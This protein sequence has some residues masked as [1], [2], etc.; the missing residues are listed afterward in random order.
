MGDTLHIVLSGPDANSFTIVSRMARFRRR[1]V[2]TT[3]TKE[4]CL[5][6]ECEV[7]DG[8]GGTALFQRDCF[9]SSIFR[10]PIKVCKGKEKG[11]EL[12]PDF[13]FGLS[14]L[15][16]N[17]FP[18]SASHIRM[19]PL[20]CDAPI[21][22][23]S[24]QSAIERAIAAAEANGR[25][26]VFFPPG[27]FLVNTDADNDEPIRISSSNIVLKGSGSRKGGTVIRQVNPRLP[28]TGAIYSTPRMFIFS[29]RDDAAY[30]RTETRITESSDRIILITVA[31]ASEFQVGQWIKIAM[32]TTPLS[33]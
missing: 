10:L 8:R 25:G 26:I 6:G 3:T 9:L 31:D 30:H 32:N 2:L 29:P 19:S 21:D 13:L 1:K 27:E 18:M 15:Q 20:W 4:T 11:H 5:L 16:Q 22:A 17:P 33:S 14:L 24:D 7:E 28:R 12:V 23:L